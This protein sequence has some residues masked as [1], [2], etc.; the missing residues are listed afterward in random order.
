MKD[1]MLI[2]E[3]IALDWPLY[4][5]DDYGILLALDCPYCICPTLKL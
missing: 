4:Y 2:A 5:S 1:Y 3:V